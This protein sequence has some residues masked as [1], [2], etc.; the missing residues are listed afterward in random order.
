VQNQNN[1]IAKI[2]LNRSGTRGHLISRTTDAR[3]DV[4]TTIA[5]YGRR[6]YLPNAR[7][8]TPPAPTTPYTA[9]AVPRP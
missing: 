5:E 7:F 2:A 4:P 9:V 1:V 6:F 8:S 3:F